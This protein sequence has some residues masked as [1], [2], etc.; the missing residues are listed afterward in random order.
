MALP[1]L[2]DFFALPAAQRGPLLVE[3]IREAHR[4]HFARNAAYRRTVSAR[5]VGEE[6]HP[7]RFQRLLR[8]ASLTFKSYV[9]TIGPFPQDHPRAFLSWLGDQLS[10]PL[11]ADRRSALRR[12]S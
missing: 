12:R 9:E 1:G 10:I 3:G 11:P 8:P 5:G 6:V 7:E 4:H 2:D